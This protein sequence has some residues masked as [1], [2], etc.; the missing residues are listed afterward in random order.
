MRRS[1]WL[2]PNLAMAEVSPGFGVSSD[3]DGP[4]GK[5]GAAEIHGRGPAYPPATGSCARARSA[6]PGP[7]AAPVGLSKPIFRFTHSRSVW[8]TT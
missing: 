5:G 8:N 1:G 7:G 4:D 3:G 6:W 2:R